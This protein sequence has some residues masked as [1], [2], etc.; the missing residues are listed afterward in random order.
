M[1]DI[2]LT[3]DGPVSVPLNYNVPNGGELLPKTVEASIDGSSAV[4]PFYA[5]LQVLDPSGRSMA[6]GITSSIAAGASADVTWFPKLS[7][8]AASSSSGSGPA[9]LYDLTL[10]GTTANF[11]TG[12]GGIPQ[13]HKDLMVVTSLRTTE[14]IV[15]REDGAIQINGDNA[16]ANYKSHRLSLQGTTV[17]GVTA[18]ASAGLNCLMCAGASAD[19]G[20]YATSYAYIPNY[21]AVKT[22]GAFGIESG[23]GTFAS[24]ANWWLYLT[25]TFYDQAAAISQIVVIP[26]TGGGGQFVAGSRCTIYGMG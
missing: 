3:R 22:H 25:N 9:V 8:Q 18:T 5:V 20:T 26:N 17:A 4:V 6:K 24:S 16:A 10:T 13:T 15:L 7:Q 23:I 21:T 19:A 2:E 1:P 14:A 12:V 11:D